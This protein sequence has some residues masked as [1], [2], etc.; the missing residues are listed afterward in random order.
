MKI[1]IVLFNLGGPDSLNAVKPFLFNLF[2]DKAIIRLP[3]P[4]RYLVA[5]LISTK[6][7]PV[8][9]AIYAQMG[10]A[11]PILP[12]T[13]KQ[14]QALEKT[15]SDHETKCFIAMRYWHPFTDET[16][17]RV[18]DFAP[19]QILL[20]PLYPQFS[21]TTTA[22]SLQTWHS[23]AKNA[24]LATPVKTVCCY[25][26]EVGFIGAM[27]TRIRKAYD[28]AKSHGNPR[29]LFSAHGLPEKIVKAGDPYQWQCEQTAKELIAAL[30]IPDL[31]AVTCYQS[32]VG[33]MQWITPSTDTVILE[34][35]REKRPIVVAP[36]AFVSDHSETLVEIDM[37]YRHLA[38]HNGAPY[39][40]Y[41]GVVG[42][43]AGFIEGLARLVRESLG[44]SAACRSDK[45]KR[46]CPKHF[47][48]CAQE[49]LCN[50]V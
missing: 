31:D 34:T 14:A 9:Q 8:A 1:A 5:K 39:F 25:P 15:L 41:T 38:M 4:L 2:S 27:A 24:G 44:G 30:N 3:Q 10:G 50:V 35:A 22:S 23:A 26:D 19:D 43:D 29:L 21:T 18:Q 17:K 7:D 20:L 16:V 47:T 45:A 48:G 13:Q 11:S 42:D 37:E 32:R 6:R 36:I 28:E 12:N 40:S 33:P 46:I 49:E